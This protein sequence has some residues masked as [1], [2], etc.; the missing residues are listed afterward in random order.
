ML[1]AGRMEYWEQLVVDTFQEF[2]QT[3]TFLRDYSKANTEEFFAVCVEAFFE[4]PEKFKREL[5]E[6][7]QLLQFLLNQDPHN[8]H[9]D[10]Q[11]SEGYL[12]G[13]RYELPLPENVKVSY[14]YSNHHWSINLLVL[15]TIGFIPTVFIVSRYFLFSSFGYFLLFMCLGTL[16]LL[17]KRYFFERKILSGYYFVMYSYAGFGASFTILLLWLNFLVPVTSTQVEKFRIHYD[18]GAY[19]YTSIA[20]P[21][22]VA[23]EKELHNN[24]QVINHKGNKRNKYLVFNYHYGILG[25]KKVDDFYFTDQ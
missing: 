17:Q 13:N 23:L 18:D 20:K 19:G 22:N 14:K 15:G 24:V 7:F 4:S 5:P 8:K 16:G 10:Y 12:T 25:I 1:F 6:I 9:M 2:S 3:P 11:I 21:R